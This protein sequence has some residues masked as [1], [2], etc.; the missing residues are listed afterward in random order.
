MKLPKTKRGI[1]KA[2]IICVIAVHVVAFVSVIS[3]QTIG[4]PHFFGKVFMVSATALNTAYIFP[5][6][7]VFGPNNAVA[8]PFYKLRDFLYK[9]GWKFFPEDDAER[10]MWWYAV[11]YKDFYEVHSVPL[12]VE[13]RESDSDEASRALGEWTDEIYSHL[14]PLALLPLEDATMKRK[15]LVAFQQ[16]ADYYL[17]THRAFVNHRDRN[18]GKLHYFS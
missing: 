15:R 3:A 14:K 4:R 6:S 12:I 10:E 17:I 2:I 8:L 11:R 13:H 16:A 7:K 18:L 1:L 5:L 9:T